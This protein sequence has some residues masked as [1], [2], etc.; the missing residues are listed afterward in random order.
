MRQKTNNLRDRFSNIFFII[1]VKINHVCDGNMRYLIFFFR[2]EYGAVISQLVN[3]IYSLNE[4]TLPYKLSHI[5]KA[6]F[7]KLKDL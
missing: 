2:T 7:H 6:A 1:F 5:E 4:Y 3:G